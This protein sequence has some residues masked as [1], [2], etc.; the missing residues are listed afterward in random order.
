VTTIHVQATLREKELFD[1]VE[2]KVKA[3]P[4]LAEGALKQYNQIQD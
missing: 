3:P 4:K 1:V 2:G